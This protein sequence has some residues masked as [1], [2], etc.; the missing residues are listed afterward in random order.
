MVHEYIFSYDTFVPTFKT[1]AERRCPNAR[2]RT[3]KPL[4]SQS[5][6]PD[7]APDP[8][9]TAA[10]Q[11]SSP[12]PG[13]PPDD[14]NLER[15]LYTRAACTSEFWNI[16]CQHEHRLASLTPISLKGVFDAAVPGNQR[17][18]SWSKKKI[19]NALA[20]FLKDFREMSASTPPKQPR[21][22]AAHE[23]PEQPPTP[24]HETLRISRRTSTPSEHG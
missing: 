13:E 11:R 10:A 1:L 4:G 15:H 9:R 3:M 21:P 12:E 24:S 2:Q 18:P 6:G 20:A 7:A 23:Y 22:A 16:L 8:G 5:G 19:L 17:D 14:G